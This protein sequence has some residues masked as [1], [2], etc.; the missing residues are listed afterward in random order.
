MIEHPEVRRRV[1]E[2]RS[3]VALEVL[4]VVYALLAT[5]VLIRSTLVLLR[6]SDRV[7]VGSLIYGLTSPVTEP[8]SMIPGFNQALLGS[9]TMVDLILLGMVVLF[10]LGMIATGGRSIR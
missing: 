6:I 8:L 5:I 9:F 3:Q 2:Q 4:L 10:P 7:W 1:Q